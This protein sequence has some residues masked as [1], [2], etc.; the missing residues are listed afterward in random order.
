MAAEKSSVA[1]VTEETST[2]E[3]N[4]P[5][6]SESKAPWKIKYLTLKAKCEQVDQVRS[7]APA[8][9]SSHSVCLEN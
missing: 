9:D 3:S 8:R 5:T 4:G 7:P 1:T 6:L 2:M